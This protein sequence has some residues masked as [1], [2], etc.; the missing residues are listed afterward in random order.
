MITRPR[1]FVSYS[2]R[3]QG[4]VSELMTHLTPFLQGIRQKY[5]SLVGDFDAKR[6]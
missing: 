5:G 1:I 4:F 2:H 6:D 3:D